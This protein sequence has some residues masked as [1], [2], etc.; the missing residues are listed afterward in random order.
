M[1]Y[2]LSKTQFRVV[3]DNRHAKPCCCFFL[4]YFIQVANLS[5][6][7]SSNT[8]GV[9]LVRVVTKKIHELCPQ[10]SND[11]LKICKEGLVK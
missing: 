7:V 4:F 8:E 10:V 1:H 11:R 5:C 6:S 3:T 9:K 2:F